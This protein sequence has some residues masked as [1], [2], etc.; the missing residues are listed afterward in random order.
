L[1]AC[2]PYGEVMELTLNWRAEDMDD[3]V[4]VGT[5][6]DCCLLIEENNEFVL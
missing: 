4:I 3:D 1:I 2:Y 5:I 6:T